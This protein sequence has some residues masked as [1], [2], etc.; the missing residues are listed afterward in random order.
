MLCDPFG[1]AII[2]DLGRK[3]AEEGA[4]GEV[5]IMSCFCLIQRSLNIKW[6]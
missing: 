6:D 4:D 1:M 3:L 5:S 2:L